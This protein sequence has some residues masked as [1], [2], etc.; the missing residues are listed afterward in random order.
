MQMEETSRFAYR[1]QTA[2]ILPLVY[3]YGKIMEFFNM[4]MYDHQSL[5]F[6][7]APSGERVLKIS[8]DLFGVS[9]K[10]G[11]KRRDDGETLADRHGFSP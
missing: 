8:H 3:H 6:Q 5:S 2:I 11:G 7:P 4:A 10:P 1:S 9:E